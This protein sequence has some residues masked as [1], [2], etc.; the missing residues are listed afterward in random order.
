MKSFNKSLLLA[1]LLAQ[2][3]SSFITSR[4]GRPFS[5]QNKKSH[6][7]TSLYLKRKKNFVTVKDI[8]DKVKKDAELLQSTR[9]SASKK[10]GR[11]RKRVERPKQQYMYAAQRKAMEKSGVAPKKKGE[12]SEELEEGEEVKAP[13]EEIVSLKKNLDEN[14]PIT[15]ARNLGMN[16]ALQSCHASFALVSTLLDGGEVSN[17][18]ITVNEPRIIGQLR[19]GGDEN[20]GLS[21]MFAYVIEKP[22]GWAILEGA[23]KT[24][25]TD[26]VEVKAVEVP[27][28]AAKTEKAENQKY[29]KTKG[30]GN[31]KKTKYYDEDTDA[32]DV[33]E[34]D[35]SGM[36]GVMTPEEIEEFEREGGFD[37][38]QLSDNGAKRA[39]AAVDAISQYDDDNEIEAIVDSTEEE[40]SVSV[41][42]VKPIKVSNAG[43]ANFATDSRPSV[44]TWL[45][46]LKAAEGTP[47]RGGNFWTAIAGAVE[48]DDSGLLLLCPKEKV[49]SVY[50]DYATYSAAVGNGKYLAP[51]GKKKQQVSMK[52]MAS[53]DD[54]KLEIVA[55]LKKGRDDDMVLT[56]TVSIR[57]GA[58]TASD[59]VQVCQKQ[60]LDGVRGDPSANPLDRRANRR[61]VHCSSLAVSS[62]T[63]DDVIEAEIEVSEDIRIFS[64]RR[65]HHEFNEG[66]F[67]GRG[68]LRENEY[69][70]AYREING[71]A[72]GFPGWLVDRYDKWLFVQHDQDFE[73]G[74]LPSL[75]DG[76][77]A[78]VYYFATDAD[79][80]VTGATKGVKPMLLEGKVAPDMIPIK[81]NGITYHVNF[82]ELSTG[83]FLDQRNQR[84]WLSRFCTPQTKVLNCFSHCGAFSIAAATAGAET[85][86]LDL[87]KKWLDRVGPQ[88]KAN[89]IDDSGGRHDRIYG[90][91]FDWL[92]RLGKRGDKFD[93][94]IIDPPSTSVGGKK[95]KRWSAK[96]D[97]DELVALAA[98]LVK[99]GGLLWA[100]TNSN[101]IHPIKFARMCK[102]GLVSAGI[103]DAKLERVAAM[104]SDFPVIG[105]QA[106]KNLVWRIP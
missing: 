94:V 23:K 13:V 56:T 48:V 36:L 59:A 29:A 9:E 42:E 27:V 98:P 100:T 51:K 87:D 17:E 57:D 30:K 5:I 10:S 76:S 50:V 97:Y 101:Q 58:S 43:P 32:F 64:D 63:F 82:D 95:K 7:T 11:T 38:L 65:N 85:V 75:H 8:I 47:I 93:I 81:E 44:V 90:D 24:K 35:Q 78:G 103:P 34:Y 105:P 39:K 52:G 89:N 71:A 54:S 1:L 25:K 37:G 21:G 91:C 16:P 40:F 96:N 49:D 62:L 74:P 33:V 41:D 60:L 104:P 79:R 66:S 26:E 18:V 12:E 73:K 31:Q 70:T 106:V 46:N 83:I 99:E 68:G 22:A 72:D 53:L 80:S 69:T 67:L 14:S 28:K 88:L 6:Q 84:A 20:E 77:T 3:T 45:K 2:E 61:L 4:S 19:V 15:I 86:S 92:L 55:K 102:K